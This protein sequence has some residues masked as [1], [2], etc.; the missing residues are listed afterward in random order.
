MNEPGFPLAF[1]PRPGYPM[2][3]GEIFDRLLKLMRAHFRLLVGIATAPAAAI[4]LLY[5]LAIGA[6]LLAGGLGHGAKTPDPKAMVWVV[7]PLMLLG[8]LPLVVIMALCEAAS[9]YAATRADLG[10]IA[11]V[12]EAYGAAWERAGRYVWLMILRWL[13]V[14]LPMVVGGVV[15][16]IALLMVQRGS[17]S[18]NPVA[19]FFLFP[20]I[21]VVYIS[22]LGWGIFMLLRLSLAYPACVCE[23]LT[24]MAA[25]DRSAQLTRGAKGRIFLVALIVYAL[26]YLLEILLFVVLAALFG[27]GALIFLALHVDAASPLGVTGIGFMAL[28]ALV[29]MFFLFAVVSATYSAAFALAYHDQKLRI[30]GPPP[31]ALLDAEPE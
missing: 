11:T 19:A 5:A 8:W 2:T 17:A 1:P 14:A 12:R 29:G 18:D 3:F 31:A 23:D 15:V 28:L 20:L 9:S 10:C 30:D 21:A 22:G 13:S 6:V 16:A 27:V 7:F 24:A 26:T 25:L 4:F